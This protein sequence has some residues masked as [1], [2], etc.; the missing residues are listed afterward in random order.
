M[1]LSDQNLIFYNNKVETDQ[2]EV[3]EEEEYQELG[4]EEKDFSLNLKTISSNQSDEW[5]PSGPVL[6]RG[7]LS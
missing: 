7:R 6:P 5:T 3:E 1:K 4:E 2:S